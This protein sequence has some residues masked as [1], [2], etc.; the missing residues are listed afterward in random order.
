MHSLISYILIFIF[1][2]GLHLEAAEERTIIGKV[3]SQTNSEIL[4]GA[5]IRIPNSNLGTYSSSRGIF[6]LRVPSEVKTIRVSS[7]G[8]LSENV[9]IVSAEDTIMVYLKSASVE[10]SNVLV[11]GDIEAK[12]VIKRAIARKDENVKKLKTF[13]GRLYSKLNMELDGKILTDGNVVSISTSTSKEKSD[14]YRFVLTETF[15]D[16]FYDY[17]KKIRHTEIIQRR[18]TANLEPSSNMMA[19]GN[20]ISFY[21]DEINLINTKI[22]TPLGKYAFAYYNYQIIEKQI[23]DDKYVYLISVTP[24]TRLFPAFIGTIKL[25]EGDYNLIETDLKPSESTAITFFE[26]MS[27]KQKYSESVEKI[28]YPS[29]LEIGA[30]AAVD[31]VKGFLDIKANV[32]ATSIY[33]DV[34]INKPLPDSIYDKTEKRSISVLADAD[35]A[36]NEFWEDNSLREISQEE[37]LLYARVD[38]AFAGDSI[39]TQT[40]RKSFNWR[41]FPFID[42]NRV[43]ALQLGLSPSISY[44]GMNLSSTT[45]YSFGQKEINWDLALSRS[46]NIPKFGTFIYGAGYR[47]QIQSFGFD[48]T[49]PKLLNSVFASAFHVD[50]YDYLKSR[51]A[52]LYLDFNKK[53]FS[54][55]TKVDFVNHSSLAKTTDKS[56]FVPDTV[57]REN[58][59]IDDGDYTIGYLNGHIGKVNN[60]IISSNLENEFTVASAFGSKKGEDLPF[61]SVLGKYNTSIPLFRTGYTPVKLFLTVEGGISSQNVPAQFQH[62]MPRLQAL[63]LGANQPVYLLSS[64]AGEYGGREYYAFHAVLNTSD[65]WWR[66]LGLPTFEGR[67]PSLILS[68]TYSRFFTMG[69]SIYKDTGNHHYSEVGFGLTRIP[70]YISNVIFLTFDARWGIGPLASGNFGWSMSISLPF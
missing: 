42:Y 16:I 31:I 34:E 47:S 56:L 8:H 18:Q 36:K 24:S 48:K 1:I 21:D 32:K 5:T 62:R 3:L 12:E 69:E 60:F 63:M 38:S 30:K 44:Y 33:S 14:K 68:S 23:Y 51:G 10:K 15:S 19:I 9:N 59:V 57:W 70:T 43:A 50:F 40:A 6:R 39:K 64:K 35:S 2:S 41:L 55:N 49:Y 7:I 58:P 53:D 65:L 4:P 66:F 29:F 61:F 25:L 46:S 67:G 13:K 37:E 22:V 52:F 45:F 27:I 17:E 20:F 54:I 26:G 28:W 11:T